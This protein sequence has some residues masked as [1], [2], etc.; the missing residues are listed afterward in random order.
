MRCDRVEEIS[1]LIDGEL[2]PEQVR[3]LSAHILNCQECQNL[4]ADF[5]NLRNEITGFNPALDPSRSRQRLAQILGREYP[6][7]ASTRLPIPAVWGWAGSTWGFATVALIVVASVVGLLVY[8]VVHRPITP[9]VQDN[10]IANEKN[11]SPRNANTGIAKPDQPDDSN[12]RETGKPGPKKPKTRPGRRVEPPKPRFAPPEL[13][14][15]YG[16]QVIATNN[17][18]RSEDNRITPAD[19]QTLTAKHFEQSEVLLRSFRNVRSTDTARPEIAY[20]RQR[21]QKLV[22]QNI[23][24]RREAD[25]SGDVQ[26]T[27]LLDSLEPILLDIANL[28]DRPHE[29]DVRLIKERMQRKNLV[30]LLQVNSVAIALAND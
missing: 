3:N 15:P 28:P 20:E 29:D 9:L 11:K 1:A 4:R 16:S 17:D 30:A 14:S 25:A 21:A 26:V 27:S 19:T 12:S 22:Y 7:P 23:L 10:Y 24:L 5:L 18:Q 8:R 6:K 2:S 13:A